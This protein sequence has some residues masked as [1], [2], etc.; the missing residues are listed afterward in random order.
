LLRAV[1]LSNGRW[2]FYEVVKVL[3]KRLHKVEIEKDLNQGSVVRR[4]G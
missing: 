1:S 4:K 2:T 3:G